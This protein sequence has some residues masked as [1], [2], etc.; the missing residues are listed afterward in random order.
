[1]NIQF[2]QCMYLNISCFCQNNTATHLKFGQQLYWIYTQGQSLIMNLGPAL[3]SLIADIL[4]YSIQF[5]FVV[6]LSFS[7]RKYSLK[8]QFGVDIATGCNKGWSE[9]LVL[10]ADYH[11]ADKNIS[12]GTYRH[13][14]E[15]MYSNCIYS[16]ISNLLLCT[17]VKTKICK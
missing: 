5:I 1:M 3:Q 6:C 11:K 14:I 8:Y 7:L 16:C 9:E 12:N 17:N 10:T 15:D 13:C 4:I 2:T